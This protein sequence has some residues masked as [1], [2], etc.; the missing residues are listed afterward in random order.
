VPR[1]PAAFRRPYQTAQAHGGFFTAR[2]ARDGLSSYR[3]NSYMLNNSDHI[4]RGTK[5]SVSV[6]RNATIEASA[7]GLS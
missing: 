2:Q 5:P 1:N 7:S 6:L 4:F 3:L